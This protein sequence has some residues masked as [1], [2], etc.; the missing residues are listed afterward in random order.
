M[1]IGGFSLATRP[2]FE[3]FVKNWNSRVI[4][5]FVWF[6]GFSIICLKNISFYW[7]L[8][9]IFASYSFFSFCP[10]HWIELFPP[11]TI[12]FTIICV[13]KVPPMIFD[14]KENFKTFFKQ[15]LNKLW[16]FYDS[17]SQLHITFQAQ[18]S[19]FWPTN[20]WGTKCKLCF[21]HQGKRA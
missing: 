12:I 8:T 14:I 16:V 10:W 15:F 13:S 20:L 11:K 18:Y 1:K 3:T 4:T 21:W 17:I 2:E 19:K 5:A 7:F 6:A 9:D